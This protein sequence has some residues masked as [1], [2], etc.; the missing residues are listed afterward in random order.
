MARK[1]D[2]Q[3]IVYMRSLNSWGNR[4]W[5]K[6]VDEPVI[7]KIVQKTYFSGGRKGETYNVKVCNICTTS[8]P[9]GE[10]DFHGEYAHKGGRKCN[11]FG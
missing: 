4:P 10:G 1:V 8:H 6:Q 2:V 5:Y 9:P 11:D 3:G 7:M